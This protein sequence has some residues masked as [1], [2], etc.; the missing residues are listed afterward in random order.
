MTYV[1][2]MASTSFVFLVWALVDLRRFSDYNHRREIAARAFVAW[3]LM[4]GAT[5][6]MAVKYEAQMSRNSKGVRH[7][8]G[9]AFALQ[10]VLEP[11]ELQSRSVPKGEETQGTVSATTH[12]GRFVSVNRRRDTSGP[13]SARAGRTGGSDGG[14]RHFHGQLGAE[15]PGSSGSSGVLS[16]GEPRLGLKF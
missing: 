1:G 5:A 7:A 11:C 9:I 15:I 6:H 14:V 16:G 4:A 3:L 13:L 2:L 10:E 8:S 12:G